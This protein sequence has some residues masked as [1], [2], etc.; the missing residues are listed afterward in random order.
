MPL[1]KPQSALLGYNRHALSSNALPRRIFLK[2]VAGAS[3]ALAIDT[4]VLSANAA[5]AAEPPIGYQS[6]SPEEGAFTE[7]LVNVMCPADG[8]TPNGVDCGLASFFDRQLAGGFGR[9]DRLYR[10]PPVRTGKPQAGYP[11]TKSSVARTT[12]CGRC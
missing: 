11:Q 1:M 5:P 2:Q 10:Q 8:L 9:G 12:C 7:A 6:L 4:A 3:G